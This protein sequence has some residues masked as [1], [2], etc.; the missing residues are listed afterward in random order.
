LLVHAAP[1]AILMTGISRVA[2]FTGVVMYGV[3]MFG[4]TGG[5]HR[6]FSHRS[7]KATR[8]FQ[9]FLAV[10]G[11]S[12]AQMGPLWWATHHRLHHR[13]TDQAG[14]AHSP[15]T[16]GFFWSHI[17]WLLCNKYLPENMVL[18]KDFDRYP[19]LRFIER[20]HYLFP[21]ALGALTF[22]AGV[23]LGTWSPAL[24]TNG[25]QMLFVSFFG[26]T[27]LLYHGTFTVNSVAHIWGRRRFET[28]DSSR[29]N[30]WVALL[31]LG[32]GWH[33]NHH[34]FPSRERHG[35]A[36]WEFDPTHG[37]LRIAEKLGW[38]SDLR[39]PAAIRR[40]S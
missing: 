37:L 3:R 12:A 18:V 2:L 30:L 39:D 6:Y 23:A 8:S 5:Y 20:N 36:W 27:L 34:R 28:A 26:S 32:E 7:Y 24:G 31:T 9:L 10:L 22:F 35:I 11:A 19:E 15:V 13:H 38:V 14:D 25:W 16:H 17:G 21:I 4:I 33:N 29:N 40:T 1:L